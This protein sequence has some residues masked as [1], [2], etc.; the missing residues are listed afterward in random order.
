MSGIRGDLCETDELLEAAEKTKKRDYIEQRTEKGEQLYSPWQLHKGNT[1][2]RPKTPDEIFE[3]RIWLLLFNLGFKSLNSDRQCR[4]EYKAYTKQIDVLGR[5][6]S[7]AFVVQCRTTESETNKIQARG[8]LE[9]FAAHHDEI[10]KAL[11]DYWGHGSFASVCHIVALGSREERGID[12]DYVQKNPQHNLHLW[13]LND[14]EYMEQLV[15]SVGPIARQQ[16]YAVM[17][18]GRRN[19][20]IEHTYPAI[21]ARIGNRTVYNFLVSA[22]ELANHVYVHHR[23]L[24]SLT[25]ASQAYQRM[26]RPLKLKQIREFLDNDNGFFANNII[27]NFNK[28]LEWT[29]IKAS[30]SVEIGTIKLP[31]YYGCAW[32]IDGQHRLYGA[33]SA[34]KDVLLPVIALEQYSEAKQA[35]LFVEINKK[36]TAVAGNLLWDLYSDIYRDS[37]QPR[38]AKLWM[39]SE[40][41]KRIS[42]DGPLQMKIEFESD[43]RTHKAPLTLNTVCTSISQNCPWDILAREGTAEQKVKNVARAINC[44]FSAVKSLRETEW[45]DPAS[46]KIILTNNGFAVFFLLFSDIV[47]HFNHTDQKSL[48]TP[49]NVNRLTEEI[50]K[51]LQP[52]IEL[53]VNDAARAQAITKGTA[54]GLQANNAREMAKIIHDFCDNFSPPRLAGVVAD[55]PEKSPLPGGTLIRERA[56]SFEKV[57]RE[58]V[59][60]K[61]TE[62]HG[63]QW[64]KCGLPGDL[65]RELD[66]QWKKNLVKAPELQNNRDPNKTKFSYCDITRV[67]SVIKYGE[68]WERE[69]GG[70]VSDFAC[71][72]NELDRRILGVKAIRDA[73]GH[74]REAAP[75]ELLVAAVELRWFSQVLGDNSLNP[76]AT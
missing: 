16:L 69:E 46:G 18:Q 25:E 59:V 36:Q 57:L 17:L 24:S 70:F 65:K 55:Q 31:G 40:V 22:K 27:L 54:R 29:R 61:L 47:K 23:K 30:D 60:A 21:K 45:S 4:L 68:N 1:W 26:L 49:S 74:S 6:D 51:L 76:Y 11:A 5:D 56:V 48:F 41:A 75:Q 12:E 37:E 33:A 62:W 72:K 10:R 9:E 39:V 66:E 34:N 53:G 8:M 3:D 13:S 20:K 19:S 43:L 28:P 64:W 42:R 52:A 73:Q 32:I 67:A 58:F 63:D 15:E 7:H 71:E 14:I 38:E 44:F 2:R 35:E 50:G